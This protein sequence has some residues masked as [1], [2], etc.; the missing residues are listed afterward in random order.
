M[1]AAMAQVQ[2][3]ASK[4]GLPYKVVAQKLVRCA[5]DRSS[6]HWQLV[7]VHRDTGFKWLCSRPRP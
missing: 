5:P 3:L 1:L 7:K 4:Y 2:E 6:C